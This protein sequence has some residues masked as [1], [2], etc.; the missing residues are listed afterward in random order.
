MIDGF[1][2]NDYNDRL[3]TLGQTT[4]E[5]RRKRGDL[6]ETL[7]IIKGFENVD[8]V[9]F[10]PLA[11]KNAHLCGHELNFFLKDVKLNLRKNLLSQMVV[12]DWNKLPETVINSTSIN[13]FKNRLD[14]YLM[15]SRGYI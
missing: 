6:I 9:L 3:K 15:F 4:L 11:I 10:F 5:T 8:S 2:D 13:M 1:A 7:K 12:N 14:C